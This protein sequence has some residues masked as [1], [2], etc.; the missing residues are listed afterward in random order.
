[1]SLLTA[2]NVVKS[3]TDGPRVLDGVNLTID[4][5]E[6]VAVMGPSGSGK[7]TLLYCI[8]GMDPMDSGSV[9]LGDTEITA[10]SEDERTT[11]RG[12]RMGFV[13]QDPNLLESLNVGDNIVLAASL[14]GHAS[15]TDL[16][17]R[18]QELMARTGIDGL[19]D[20]GISEISGGQRQRVSLC[21]ALLHRPDL[22]FG[23]EPT[24]ALNSQSSAEVIDL[25]AEF[26]AEGMTML[27]V[28]HDA[29]VAA[30]AGRVVFLSDGR[31]VDELHPTGDAPQREH[32]V[33]EVM[34]R[35]GI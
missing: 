3:F 11:L 32:E 20:R 34:S 28:T 29:K 27:I 17:T 15:S 9:V 5:S 26:N 22:L 2:T 10:L 31:I 6:F 24:G 8:S 1:M 23:D 4:T 25:L 7:S 30:R 35:H 12:A 19:A 14:Q 16:A 18:A 21:R 33:L 13:F